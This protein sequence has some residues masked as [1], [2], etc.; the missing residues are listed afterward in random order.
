M[1]DPDHPGGGTIAESTAEDSAELDVDSVA[2]LVDDVIENIEQV[3]V[4]NRD[5]IEH[6]LIALL[7]RGHVLIEDV[8]GVGKTMLARALASS[9]DCS[10]RRVQ[11]TP[12][13]LP[14][15]ITGVNVYNQKTQEF[16]FK[17]GPIFANV[18]LGDEI[19][20]APPKTQSALL[21][22]MEEQHVTIDGETHALPTPFTV[23]A[24]QN[25][26][27][28]H[29]TYDLPIAELDRFMKAIK[30]GYPD[31]TEEVELLDRVVG[32][33]PIDDVE[34]VVSSAAIRQA[35]QVV[36]SV[37]V[38]E[39]VRTYATDLVGYTR[40]RAEL[41]ASPRGTIV[42]IRAAQ[43]RAALHG[44]G[45]VIPDDIQEEAMSVLA[46]RI[47]PN[48]DETERDGADLVENALKT[49]HVP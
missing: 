40:Q 30:L 17:P 2:Q 49:I 5:S 28:P 18:V 26:I 22:A 11:F 47:R 24:T 16:E 19:N 32:S 35:Q 36:S 42:L 23:L 41:G 25:V 12:D 15:D 33:H 27:E 8:P 39:P 46:H 48:L 37:T 43:G 6:V 31:E 38:E 4:G 44:R 14:S 3:H 13:L 1:T 10:F 29:R 9:I 21:E 34:P 45:Y 7:G 20:R